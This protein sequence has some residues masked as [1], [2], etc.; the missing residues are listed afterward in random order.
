M[1]GT[2]RFVW[3][4]VTLAAVACPCLVAGNELP[5][6]AASAV[7]NLDAGDGL[8]ATLF[9]S[10]PEISNVTCLDVDH[11]G[12]VWVG[13]VKNYRHHRNSRPRGDRILVLEDIDGDGRADRHTVFHQG[14]EIDSVHGICVLGRRVIAS[15]GD[16]VLVLHDDD[17]DL[18]S[19]R[20]EVLFSGI[21]GVQHDHGIHSFVFGPDGRL[22]F[23]FGNEGRQLKD[24]EGRPV[25]DLAGNEV[26]AARKPYQEGMVF[27]CRLDGSEVETLGWNFRNN[28][29]LALDSFGTIWQS[30]NDDD[31]NQGTRINYVMEFGNYGYKDEHTGA[32]WGQPRTNIEAEIPRRHWHLN[33]PGV[34]PNLLQTGQGSPTGICVYEGALLPDR[35]RGQVIHCDAGPSVCR[36]YVTRRDGAGYAAEIVDVLR[37]ARDNWYR[38]SDVVVAPDGSLFVG[39]WYDPGVGGHNQQEVD[40]GRIFRVAPPGSRYAPP[41]HDFSTAA[42]AA[43][44]LASPNPATW[45]MAWE[46]LGG[47]GPD[48]VTEVMRLWNTKGDDRLRARAAWFL[49]SVPGQADTVVDLAAAE[50]NPDLRIVAL[51][52]ARARKLDVLR[53]VRRLCEDSAAGVRRECA[54]SLRGVAAPDAAEPWATLALQHDGQDRW[55]LEALGIGA[56]GKWDACLDAYLARVG[57]KLMTD[58]GKDVVWRSRG[59]KTPALLARIIKDASTPEA[60]KP[61][62]LRSFDFLAKGPEKDAALQELITLD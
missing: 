27:R 55:Y 3:T 21:G 9:S 6:E 12:R 26:S 62:Y 22:Y 51:R 40:K 47:Q 39:D 42:G 11:L 1:I 4:V 54:I 52:L 53:L 18:A 8:E 7:A 38:P 31:G 61:K 20:T 10:E 14:R 23:N 43:A 46:A 37:G 2:Q 59:T 35:Y 36:A 50:A 16:K 34:V 19:D 30:D 48:A 33:D 28:W 60:A 49:G 29:E 45:F 5:R 56:A 57:D 13:E 17:G 24:R 44:A 41:R 15:A 25:V 58:A 32:A